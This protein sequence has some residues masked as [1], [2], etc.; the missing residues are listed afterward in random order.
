MTDGSSATVRRSSWKRKKPGKLVNF[1]RG[2]RGN[3][4]FT[5]NSLTKLFRNRERVLGDIVD[6]QPVY[7]RP[8]VR[9][10]PGATTTPPSRQ[11]APR[12]PMLYVGANDGMLHAFYATLNL[13]RRSAT[14]RKPGR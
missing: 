2:H 6:S 8:A 9:E 5:S 11:H 4:D 10:L 3:E 7:V 14:V 1:L 12:T 13:L